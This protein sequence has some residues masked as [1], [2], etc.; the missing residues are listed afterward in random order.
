MFTRCQKAIANAKAT[1]VFKSKP[2]Y[3]FGGDALHSGLA[4]S[5]TKREFTPWQT[6]RTSKSNTKDLIREQIKNPLTK[7]EVKEGFLYVYSYELDFGY[8]KI[9]ITTR[10]HEQRFSEFRRKC[11]AQPKLAYIT[12][13]KIPHVERVEKL[14]HAELQ[15]VRFKMKC[16]C[17]V[18]HKE[19]FKTPSTDFK[20]VVKKWA[21]WIQQQPYNIESRK[22]HEEVSGDLERLCVPLKPP[23]VDLPKETQ[24]RVLRSRV[25]PVEA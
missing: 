21:D 10:S 13:V 18:E 23:T 14:V 11:K 2:W 24:F 19:W 3:N 5:Q 16:G 1:D 25:V 7:R 22:L 20:A 8:C 15:A 6:K 9:G 12:P 4:P 17:G